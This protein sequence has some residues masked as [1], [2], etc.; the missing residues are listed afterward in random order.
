MQWD[1]LQMLVYAKK[2][3]SGIAKLFIS[4]ER[5]IISWQLLKSAL[6]SEFKSTISSAELH[7]ML[8]ERKMAKSESTHEYLLAMKALSLQGD[9]DDESLI[10]YVIDGIR[11]TKVNKK[12]RYN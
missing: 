4:S 9:I 6:I 3:L 8:S 12:I 11:N 2:S 5:G 10:Q 1:D 7:K